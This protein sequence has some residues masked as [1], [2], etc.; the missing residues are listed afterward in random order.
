MSSKG[1]K[2]G[3]STTECARLSKYKITEANG[4]KQVKCGRAQ[5]CK[6]EDD[7]QVNFRV[8]RRL[9]RLIEQSAMIQMIEVCQ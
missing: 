3:W 4:I 8:V 6:I 2:Q 5:D 9:K 7:E 1:V